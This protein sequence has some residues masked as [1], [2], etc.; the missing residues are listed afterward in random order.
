MRVAVREKTKG[1]QTPW[2]STSLTGDF[3]PAGEKVSAL[4][5]AQQIAAAGPVQEAPKPAPVMQYEDAAQR[6]VRT[7]F[8]GHSGSIISVA[9]S[10]DGRWRLRARAS[11]T[12]IKLWDVA[13]GRE[14]HTFTGHTAS[15][16]S[17]YAFSPDGRTL[18]STGNDRRS[19][20]GMQRAAGSCAHSPGIRVLVRSVAFF[21][22]G[23]TLASASRDNTLKLWDAASGRELRR[24]HRAWGMEKVLAF[25]PDGRRLRA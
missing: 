21:P 3:Y 5:P 10:P 22:D 25:S 7:F 19:S 20:C 23:R 1:E 2:E 15:V 9:F 8:T 12:T 24:L 14:L 11:D 16:L 18:A 4:E 17:V 6:L 13:G